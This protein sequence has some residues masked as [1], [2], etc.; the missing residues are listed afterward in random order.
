M[1]HFVLKCPLYDEERT[2][3]F[4]VLGKEDAHFDKRTDEG[5]TRII[6]NVQP[7]TRVTETEVAQQPSIQKI[8]SYLKTAYSKRLDLKP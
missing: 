3:L 5:K 6:L 2:Q 4:D 1:Q 7:K 8:C